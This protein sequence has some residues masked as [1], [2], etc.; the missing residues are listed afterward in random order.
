MNGKCEVFIIAAVADNG[1]IGAGDAMPWRLASDLKR[2]KALTLGKPVIMGRRTFRALGRPLPDRPNI[3]VSRS[4]A[5]DAAPGVIVAASLEA[6]LAEA[7]RLA[8]RADGEIAVI[9][10]AEIYEAAL[11]IADR[12]EITRVHAAPEGDVEF[13]PVD[14]SRW[15]EVAAARHPAGERDEHP[16]TFVTYLRR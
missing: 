15:K 16:F 8:S 5:V 1:V 3:V 11:P 9:G 12:L 10:G 6:A 7:R 14:W 2:F 4:G 13:P